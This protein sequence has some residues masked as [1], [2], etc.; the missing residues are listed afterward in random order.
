[1][2]Q[3]RTVGSHKTV[4]FTQGGVTRVVYQSTAVVEFS[5]LII[6]LNTGGWFTSTTKTRMNQASNQ[7][8]L[9][10][11]VYQKKGQWFVNAKYYDEPLPFV[12]GVVSFSSHKQKAL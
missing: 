1:M 4:V 5:D 6:T 12:D 10:F 9:G 2:A 3:Q 11:R 7:F 8:E